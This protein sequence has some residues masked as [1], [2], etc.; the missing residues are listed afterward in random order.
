MFPTVIVPV[1]QTPQSERAL[2][3]AVAL[4][5]AVGG[6]VE[7]VTVDSPRTDTTE[8]EWYQSCLAASLPEAV[9]GQGVISR[10]DAPVPDQLVEVGRR[11]PS[12]VICLATAGRGRV[13]ELLEGSVAAGLVRQSTRPVLLV[14]PEAVAEPPSELLVG[15]VVAALDGSEADA[16]VLAA[17]GE[18]AASLDEGVALV[19]V[20]TGHGDESTRAEGRRVL[21]AAEDV[22]AGF[23]VTA[24]TLLAIASD[25][26]PAILGMTSAAT[27]ALVVGSHRRGPF[28]RLAHAAT[29]MWLVHRAPC[30]VLVVPAARAS[31]ASTDLA[32][33]AVVDD[34]V[35][36]ASA[37][38][39]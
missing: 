21:D 1:E 24:T 14:G 16:D 9:R 34:E 31:V 15:S 33:S 20:I 35:A 13:G 11:F 10:A 19:H 6:R 23:G 12:S 3:V 28:G 29:A 25:P 27:S 30:P 36:P 7:L 26:A 18:L 37:S 5:N 8:T 2:P 4:A 22:L 32:A 17:A 39:G 38:V